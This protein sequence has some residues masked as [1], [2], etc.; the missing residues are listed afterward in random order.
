MVDW[1]PNSGAKGSYVKQMVQD[2]LIVY[3]HYIDKHVEDLPEIRNWKWEPEQC[4]Q[5]GRSRAIIGKD[6]QGASDSN[7]IHGRA[8]ALETR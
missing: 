4:V 5:T 1:L 8:S 6:I 7:S 3:K 2:K